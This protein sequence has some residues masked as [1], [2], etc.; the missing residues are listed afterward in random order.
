MWESKRRFGVSPSA[1]LLRHTSLWA[2]GDLLYMPHGI[3]RWRGQVRMHWT[4]ESTTFWWVCDILTLCWANTRC[5]VKPSYTFKPSYQSRPYQVFASEVNKRLQCS[6]SQ[7]VHQLVYHKDDEV[8]KFD[9]GGF[10]FVVQS[11]IKL[12]PS[13]SCMSAGY[14]VEVK[15]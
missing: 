1:W 2:T 10:W 5:C 12:D 3:L 13:G 6:A 8:R 4:A 14:H 15:L 7:S 11:I 9:A